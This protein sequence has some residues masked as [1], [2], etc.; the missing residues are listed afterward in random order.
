MYLVL[1]ATTRTLKNLRRLLLPVLHLNVFDEYY[2]MYGRTTQ[3]NNIILLYH[4][5][6]ILWILRVRIL[7]EYELV[8]QAGSM[9]STLE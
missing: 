7:L 9:N 5:L 3:Y 4:A 8:L 1:V 6:Y 2:N